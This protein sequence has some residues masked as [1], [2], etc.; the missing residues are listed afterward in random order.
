MHLL[1]KLIQL[2]KRRLLLQMQL[3]VCFTAWRSVA[4]S[5]SVEIISFGCLKSLL[6]TI[7]LCYF[8][9]LMI[10]KCSFCL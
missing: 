7:L 4:V 6:E 10:T 8:A 1:Q 5:Q 9:L 2:Q 3:L